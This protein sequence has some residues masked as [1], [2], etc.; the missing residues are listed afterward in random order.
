MAWKCGTASVRCVE[1]GAAHGSD[2]RKVE[3]RVATGPSLDWVY[4]GSIRTSGVQSTEWWYMIYDLISIDTRSGTW[5]SVC[6]V[7]TLLFFFFFFF[8]WRKVRKQKWKKKKKRMDGLYFGAEVMRE[9]LA[10]GS[11]NVSSWM[12]LIPCRKLK[13]NDNGRLKEEENED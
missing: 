10:K 8:F 2:S 13:S 3:R 11:M 7:R 9:K 4:F 5:W 12:T 1:T 6:T